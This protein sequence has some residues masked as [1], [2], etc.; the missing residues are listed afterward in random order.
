MK[1]PVKKKAVKMRKPADRSRVVY[2]L[3]RVSADG[4][5]SPSELHELKA[6]DTAVFDL[7][8]G[9]QVK[10]RINHSIK[11]TPEECA[12]HRKANPLPDPE[13][14]AQRRQVR[15]MAIAARYA[16]T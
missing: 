1:T 10:L 3:T 13:L 15:K 4:K 12:A 2:K 9:R 16:S 7:P 5:S 11:R 6:G 8:N 14:K